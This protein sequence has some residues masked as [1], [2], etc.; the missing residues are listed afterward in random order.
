[1]S[2]VWMLT[3][4]AAQTTANGH[5]VEQSGVEPFSSGQQAMSFDIETADCIATSEI[6]KAGAA[7]AKISPIRARI[8]NMPGTD[9]IRFIRHLL[10]HSR[11]QTTHLCVN[12]FLACD[13]C[14]IALREHRKTTSRLA[15]CQ[16]DRTA[17]GP[18]C[19]SPMKRKNQECELGVVYNRRLLSHS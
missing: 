2:G 1:M 13:P 9:R 7:G 5:T 15:L 19:R 4:R 17:F 11:P 8:A 16:G 18:G 3:K 12:G 6:A 14:S 10:P